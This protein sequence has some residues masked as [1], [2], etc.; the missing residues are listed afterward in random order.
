MHRRVVRRALV[1]GAVV[2]LLVPGVAAAQVAASI[3]PGS[4]MITP[5][6]DGRASGCTAA[7]VFR[8]TDAVHLGYA[9]HCAGDG[10][11]GL[12]GCEEPTLPLGT[13]VVVEGGDGERITGSLA[14]SSWTTM[15]ERDETS[16]ALCHLNDFALVALDPADVAAVD[17]S[18][19]EFG[20]PTGLDVDGTERGEAVFSY[21]PQRSDDATKAGVSRG[22]RAGGRTHEVAT[23]PAGIPGDSGSGYLDGDGEAFG[24]LSTQITGG[25]RTTNGV[26]D[27]ALALAYASEFGG[28]G[29]ITLVLGTAPFAR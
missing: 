3:G 12:S 1:V 13:R 25:G 26:T 20:G 22:D 17:P 6:G 29:K 4:L 19:P 16:D 8:S 7:F 28:L 9:A 24:V 2:G 11:L 18:V 21:Q 10:V 15:Q 27:L 5:L 23:V 14:Y